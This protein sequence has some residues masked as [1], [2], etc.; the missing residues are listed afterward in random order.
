MVSSPSCFRDQS[1]HF[2]HIFIYQLT[3]IELSVRD[4]VIV[5]H[6]I[7]SYFVTFSDIL[8]NLQLDDDPKERINTHLV[9]S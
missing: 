3:H 8:M 5:L 1:K 6:L 2:K 9:I 7:D 4:S